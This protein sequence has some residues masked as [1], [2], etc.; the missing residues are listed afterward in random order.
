MWLRRISSSRIA[1]INR[2]WAA[3]RSGS[4]PLSFN[5]VRNHKSSLSLKVAN[6][7]LSLSVM[8]DLSDLEASD[9]MPVTS[10]GL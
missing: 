4:K 8:K 5:R 7:V 6:S 2:Q 10:F 1:S 3:R 9:G